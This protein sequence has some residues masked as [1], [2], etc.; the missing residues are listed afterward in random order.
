YEGKLVLLG[1]RAGFRLDQCRPLLCVEH[2]LMRPETI[3]VVPRVG[4]RKRLVAIKAVAARLTPAG[5]A[6][7]RQ[8]Y[9]LAIEQAEDC[10]QR[11]HPAQLNV[12]L[13]RVSGAGVV[14]RTP[15]IAIEAH[16]LRPGKLDS[17]LGDDLCDKFASRAAGPLAAD[18]VELTL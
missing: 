5:D 6:G 16:R 15:E 3:E 12:C 8:R 4:H 18:E 7:N 17:D 2:H 9:D 14:S 11:P 13:G 10:M 1:E